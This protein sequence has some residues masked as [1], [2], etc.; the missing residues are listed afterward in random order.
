MNHKKLNRKELSEVFNNAMRGEYNSV[1]QT[2]S[3]EE[4]SVTTE[5]FDEFEPYDIDDF[6]HDRASDDVS[7]G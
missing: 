1:A 4:H 7:S 2:D 5:D 3:V 6:S